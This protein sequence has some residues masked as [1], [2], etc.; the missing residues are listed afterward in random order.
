M[1]SGNRS[2]TN[3]RS[4]AVSTESPC[5]DH[6][7][8]QAL[9]PRTVL[10]RNHHRLGHRLMAHQHRL[11]L[12]RLDPE[13]T[14]L[15][16]LIRPPTEHQLTLSRPPHQVTGAIHPRSRPTPNGAR[17]KPLGRQPR[18]IQIPPRQPRTGHIQLTDHPHR[19]RPQRPSNTNTRVLPSGRP[20]GTTTGACTPGSTV[21]VVAHTVVSVGPYR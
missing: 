13:T 10:T 9:V 18:T 6:V 12:A 21:N 16:L 4:T 15:H 5:R 3:S 2:A 11:D 17:H 1:Y 8:H 20:I 19:H 7:G 14:H